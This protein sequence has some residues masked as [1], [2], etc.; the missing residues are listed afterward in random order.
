ML[1]RFPNIAIVTPP[2]ATVSPLRIDGETG[3]RKHCMIDHARDD[4]ELARLAGVAR[5]WLQPPIGWLG[6]SV[7]RQTLRIDLP[8][9][10]CAPLKLPFAPVVSIGSIVYFDQ[11]NA[12]QTLSP[13]MYFLDEDQLLFSDTFAEP[14][15]YAR[16]YAVRITYVCGYENEEAIPEPI[17]QAMR[18]CV[19]HW[20][21]NPAATRT[22]GE[23]NSIPL[24][25]EALLQ[26]YRLWPSCP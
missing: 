25:A 21:Q 23:L 13:S 2:D 12:Q 5:D 9:W 26:P 3:L 16:P 10:W 20:Y 1:P 18:M 6:R 19:L 24:G 22:V 8:C 7:S 4:H 14:S 17:K 11:N 15:L